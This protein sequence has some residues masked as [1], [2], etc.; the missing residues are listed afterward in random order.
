M[1]RRVL[2]T[3]RPNR[4]VMS[5]SWFPNSSHGLIDFVRSFPAVWPL[6]LAL[7]LVPAFMLY[8]GRV[9]FP[10]QSRDRILSIYGMLCI[11]LFVGSDLANFLYPGFHENYES[12]GVSI[13][14]T[15]YAGGEVYPAPA[16]A[17]LYA[18]PY[19]PVFYAVLGASIQ[20]FGENIHA[21]KLPCSL[22]PLL[23]LAL[24]WSIVR[25]RGAPR[26][27]AFML[28][29]LEAAL[30]LAIRHASF[31]T[32]TDPLLLLVVT[33]AAW[34]A[35]RRDQRWSLALGACA[36]LAMG[37]KLSACGYFLPIF[38]IA[39]FSGWRPRAFAACFSSLLAVFALPFLLLPQQISFT[40]YLAFLHLV[41]QEGF[42]VAF[43][44]KY[45]RW[46]L[47][48]AGL[49]LVFNA[50]MGPAFPA[51][52]TSRL[53]G[54]LYGLALFAG[55]ALIA[56]P[57]SAVGAGS[58][59]HIPFI[60]L[61]LMA[62]MNI[63]RARESTNVKTFPLAIV[64]KAS[65]SAILLAT[66]MIAVKH[67]WWIAKM[68]LDSA[69]PAQ[70]HITDLK[71]IIQKYHGHKIL[72]GGGNAPESMHTKLRHEL[73]LAGH[74]IGLDA[75]VVSD[76]QM[77]GGAKPEM[78]RL[79]EQIKARDQRPP[80][81]LVA[82]GSDPFTAGNS[83]E[84]E[85]MVYPEDFRQEFRASYLLQ[86]QTP[87]FDLYLAPVPGRTATSETHDVAHEPAAGPG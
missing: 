77:G 1:E 81:W 59:H 73:V 7:I 10:P 37:L 5:A 8:A 62:C 74:P 49:V 66:G 57:A 41:S 51:N 76:Y 31:W 29:G 63:S 79:M 23:A 86:E 13:A 3:L 24:F 60:P 71:Q 44:M 25:S 78:D 27:L 85:R 36:G 87:Y 75:A 14:H 38:I 32:K 40:N 45:F 64:W 70:A 18:L 21:A 17:E 16:S 6:L 61:V 72:M 43:G 50:W 28:V 68:G 67:T 83:Y 12:A 53:Q 54:L 35:L 2:T 82:R 58:N 84:P 22:A 30:L 47:M 80:L 15:L 26:G 69:A 4:S 52:A 46:I 65:A 48:F 42:S 20:L 56:V 33:V 19:G 11:A 39:Y 34:I 9:G 55:F